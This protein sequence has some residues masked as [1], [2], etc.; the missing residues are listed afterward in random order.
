MRLSLYFLGIVFASMLQAQSLRAQDAS[1]QEPLTAMMRSFVEAYNT[2][3][4]ASIRSM[5]QNAHA[6]PSI[7]DKAIM[8]NLEAYGFIGKVRLRS[9][10]PVE[11]NKVEAWVQ[12]LRYDAWWKFLIITDS[13]QHYQY[14]VIQ[15][16]QFTTPFIQKG[17][18]GMDE[19]GTEV[20]KYL[21]RLVADSV[22]KGEVLI[23]KKGQVLFR[24]AFGYATDGKAPGTGRRFGM[25][26]L[27]KMFTGVAVLQLM[28][29]GRL[30]LDDTI[31]KFLPQLNN[32]AIRAR[33]T[34]RQLLTHTSGMGDFFEDS[35]YNQIK[36][37]LKTSLDYFP[38]LERDQLQFE[39]GKGWAY[40]NSGFVLLGAIIESLTGRTY[41]QYITENICRP[42]GMA[43]TEV[44]SGAGGGQST[45]NDLYAFAQALQ[46]NKLLA[47]A[48]TNLMMS[49]TTDGTWGLASIHHP[50]GKEKIVGHG[51]DYEKVCSD[52]GIYTQS[53][54]VV[55]ILSETDPPFAH[56]VADKVKELLIRE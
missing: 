28:E 52:L 9:I 16:A 8:G 39:P 41:Q 3:D 47:K 49:Y 31:G 40:S 38:I 18:L 27:G 14:R 2:G 23:A 10:N 33:V 32:P 29:K 51:G 46:S 22:F 44:G 48:S 6:E 11:V 21:G 37:R 17:Q 4:S 50:I 54:F 12:E 1:Q 56:F 34:I 15:P 13:L 45:I 53:G 36:E 25:A 30:N 35:L 55:I 43:N 42:S 5:L 7:I 19:V 26:S 24:D 20:R